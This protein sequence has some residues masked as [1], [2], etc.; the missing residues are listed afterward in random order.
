MMENLKVGNNFVRCLEVNVESH[1]GHAAFETVMGH[2][3]KNDLDQQKHG[4]GIQDS[5]RALSHDNGGEIEDM[6]VDE[7][8]EKKNV[9][10]K[11]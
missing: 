4:S 11:G 1:L 5:F 6:G 3:W 10:A 2:P 8:T 7:I 9:E